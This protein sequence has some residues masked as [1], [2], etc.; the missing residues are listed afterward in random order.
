MGR[1]PTRTLA[2]YAVTQAVTLRRSRRS[3]PIVHSATAFILAA[4]DARDRIVPLAR[5][6]FLPLIEAG[7]AHGALPFALFSKA[8]AR[9]RSVNPTSPYSS[10]SLRK[11]SRTV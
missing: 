4:G 3:S 2:R 1:D 7:E 6:P 11:A 9:W 10:M 5:E 8:R